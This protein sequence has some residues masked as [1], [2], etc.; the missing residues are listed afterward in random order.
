[1]DQNSWIRIL[2]ILF[3]LEL[4]VIGALILLS[5]DN[6]TGFWVGIVQGFF[7]VLVESLVIQQIV[8]NSEKRQHIRD[9]IREMGS[10]VNS[11][12]LVAVEELRDL[13][14]LTDGTLNGLNFDY[15][16]LRGARMSEAVLKN[17]SFCYAQLDNINLQGA[18][19][20][21]AN[22]N[23]ANIER[24]KLQLSNLCG[25]NLLLANLNN[26]KLNRAHVNHFTQL[27]IINGSYDWL[28]RSGITWVK[29][30]EEIQSR[31]K[32][33]ELS[34]RDDELTRMIKAIFASGQKGT[35]DRDFICGAL[36]VSGQ[37][38]RYQ[39]LEKSTQRYLTFTE[40]EGWQCSYNKPL[41]SFFMLPR[42]NKDSK[43][44]LIKWSDLPPFPSLK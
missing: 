9:L 35:L 33:D 12:A 20:E 44:I 27:P 28:K 37:I 10:Q 13:G 36:R 2:I 25:T 21:G 26:A 22:F 30:T 31:E 14:A 40:D 8:K 42:D 6:L 23:Y 3:I 15:A 24:G 18:D 19:L 4:I 32:I 41:K 29:F 16:D 1:M 39:I 38:V 11:T 5:G 43:V 34:H 7:F 17:T